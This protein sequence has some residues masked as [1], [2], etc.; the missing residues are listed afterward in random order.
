[1]EAH[2]LIKTS[3]STTLV[4]VP[5]T[6]VKDLLII[7]AMEHLTIPVM[8]HLIIP[9][10]VTHMEQIILKTR[11]PLFLIMAT[12]MEQVILK[13]LVLLFQ[14]METPITP[15]VAR[16][17]PTIQAKVQLIPTQM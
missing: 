15:K 5:A 12:H 2:I 1:M 6:P 14:I 3:A 8:E 11:V 9:I 16:L 17:T 10:M 4:I 13:T 7:P